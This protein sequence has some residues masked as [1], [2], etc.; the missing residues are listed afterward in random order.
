MIHVQRPKASGRFCARFIFLISVTS[1][2]VFVA[3]VY[4]NAEFGII[5]QV[6]TGAFLCPV[7]DDEHDHGPVFLLGPAKAADCEAAESRRSISIFAGY[8]AA[9][10]TKRLPDFL[11]WEC[12]HVGKARCQPTNDLGIAGTSSLA[13]TVKHSDGWIEF[14]VVTQAG[15]P[16][17]AFDP[18]AP[19]INYLLGLHTDAQDSPTDLV[20]FRA[21]LQTIRLSP[22]AQ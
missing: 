7:P 10:L 2:V 1:T 5:A 8:N 14:L 11:R 16:D 4:R 20:T 17:P 3:Q 12:V 18:I 13:G 9:Q 15:R 22:P 21:V 19:R 6:P